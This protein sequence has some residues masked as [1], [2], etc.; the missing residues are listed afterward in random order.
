M[1]PRYLTENRAKLETISQEHHEAVYL[2]EQTILCRVLGKYLVYTDAEDAGIVPH[3]CMGGCWEAWITL[4]LARLVR[5]GWRCLD[6]GANHG[7]YTLIMADGAGPTGTVLAVEPNRKPAGLLPLTLSVNGFEGWVEVVEKAA[8]DLNGEQ[9]KFLIP[10]RFGLNARVADEPGQVG[11][12]VEVETTTVDSLTTGWPRVDLIKI[13]VEGAEEAVWRG[14]QGTLARNPDLIVILEVNT[15][16]YEDPP[17]FFAKLERAGF[18]L[19]YINY[20]GELTKVSIEELATQRRG[21]DWML[22]LHR[23]GTPQK[24]KAER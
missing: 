20:D 1:I 5:P 22:F 6:L 9:V 14:M 19:R 4:A 2:G 15:N 24:V 7:Y 21:E 23:S 10:E 3:L 16:R 17:A 13:D 11:D 12:V 8:S 18:P